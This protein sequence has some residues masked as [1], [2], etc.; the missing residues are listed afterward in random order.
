MDVVRRPR[1]PPRLAAPPLPCARASRRRPDTASSF[2]RSRRGRGPRRPHPYE[3][4]WFR[5]CRGP[6]RRDALRPDQSPTRSVAC[7]AEV[8]FGGF[9]GN[10]VSPAN[11]SRR[12]AFGHPS[13]VPTLSSRRPPPLEQESPRHSDDRPLRPAWR[14]S[15]RLGNLVDLHGPRPPDDDLLVPEERER[16]WI[17]TCLRPNPV[18]EVRSA[19][20]PVDDPVGRLR[21]RPGARARGILRRARSAPRQQLR[22]RTRG[23]ARTCA[24]EIRSNRVAAVSSR[25]DLD[26]CLAHD[27]ARV[28]GL[29]H[30]LEQR[31]AGSC[32][33]GKDCPRNGGPAPVAR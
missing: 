13:L 18:V 19:G 12:R 8:P 33:P 23:S 32:Q 21:S 22:A 31:D 10:M 24:S 17:G 26:D 14:R 28:R 1:A 5:P 3:R 2:R 7:D 15:S 29:I 11:A 9:A 20:L 30:D 25:A 6:R 27:R 4:R 16:S